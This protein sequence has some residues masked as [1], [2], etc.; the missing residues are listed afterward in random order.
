MHPSRPFNKVLQEEAAAFDKN[1]TERIQHGFIPDLRRL[2][3]VEWFY[4][5]VWR[6]PEFVKIHLLPKV[7]FVIE[8][9][10]KRGGKVIELGCGTGYLTLELAR[11]GLEVVGVDISPKSIE[12]AKRFAKE[13]PYKENFGSLTYICDDI[14]TMN[15]GEEQWDTIVFFGTLHHIAEQETLMAKVHKALKQGGNLVVCEPVR[16][17]FTK[18]SALFA[19]ILRAVLPTWIPYEEKLKNLMDAQSWWNYV[20]QIY[21][22]YTYQDE[23]TQSPMDNVVASA[24]TMLKYIKKYFALQTVEYSDAF[25][26]K[27]IGGLRG[28][29]RF[30]LARFLK[31]LDNELVRKKVLPPTYVKI[32]AIKAQDC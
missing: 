22:E 1:V 4:N 12:I 7:N 24:E 11:N 16:G 14:L 6:E 5:N 27:L 18:D 19:A 29:H 3:K 17:H 25:I 21:K 26:D 2:K 32:H 13:N 15:L 20:E 23:H 10:K 8:I 9:A 28:E 31:F 30:L